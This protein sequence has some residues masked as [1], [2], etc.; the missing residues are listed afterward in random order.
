MLNYQ[1]VSPFDG[2][3]GMDEIWWSLMV[4]MFIHTHLATASCLWDDTDWGMTLARRNWSHWWN[5][6][7][8]SNGDIVAQLIWPDLTMGGTCWI[9][10][11]E[12]NY[13]AFED[14]VINPMLF[15][16]D[17]RHGSEFPFS[18]WCV[19]IDLLSHSQAHKGLIIDAGQQAEWSQ[20]GFISDL[21][22]A[23][24]LLML[25]EEWS[26]WPLFRQKCVRKVYRG[27]ISKETSQETIIM[28]LG[29]KTDSETPPDSETTRRIQKLFRWIQK[30]FR[31][32]QKLFVGRN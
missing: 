24:Y 32:I 18:I 25:M 31:W 30:L 27:L 15:S 16:I 4:P 29:T 21:V 5:W 7:V 13:P 22:E 2:K 9:I 12:W 19:P 3:K 8:G 1:R 20:S 10:F 28:V 6:R 11:C 17:A 23:V 26:Y 14:L